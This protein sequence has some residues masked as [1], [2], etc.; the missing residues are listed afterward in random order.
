MTKVAL[1]V[2]CFFGSNIN[3]LVLQLASLLVCVDVKPETYKADQIYHELLNRGMSDDV[4]M[5]I[6]PD[7]AHLIHRKRQ[8]VSC[9]SGIDSALLNNLIY[10]YHFTT[11]INA[12]D[13]VLAER[14]TSIRACIHRLLQMGFRKC[15]STN[16]HVAMYCDGVS[17]QMYANLDDFRRR[18]DVQH[19]NQL[20]RDKV[21]NI[22]QFTRPYYFIYFRCPHV[23]QNV[24]KR[25]KEL[26]NEKN[27]MFAQL[28]TYDEYTS[29]TSIR[30]AFHQACEPIE[31]IGD[32]VLTR[33]RFELLNF[34]VKYHTYVWPSILNVWQYQY[35]YHTYFRDIDHTHETK[36]I[37]EKYYP[38]GFK[39]T[40]D[41]FLEVYTY[42]SELFDDAIAQYYDEHIKA[43]AHQSYSGP[44]HNVYNEF[45][46][47]YPNSSLQG[48]TYHT[49]VMINRNRFLADYDDWHKF[50]ADDDDFTCGLDYYNII[51]QTYLK[52]VQKQFN[53][54]KPI[55]EKLFKRLGV[56]V[57]NMNIQ[58]VRQVLPSV[59]SDMDN[60]WVRYLYVIAMK[61]C[62]YDTPFVLKDK[63]VYELRHKSYS[64][65][66][67]II[68]PH[69]PYNFT[70][71]QESAS[72]DVAFVSIH[73]TD[74][75]DRA[76]MMFNFNT[77]YYFNSTA[78][79][80]QKL[81]DKTLFTA[82][83]SNSLRMV[84]KLYNPNIIINWGRYYYK[85]DSLVPFTDAHGLTTFKYVCQRDRRH[86]CE[87]VDEKEVNE[88]NDKIAQE[89]IGQLH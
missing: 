68:P 25:A 58:T 15:V 41:I 2:N 12:Y 44:I 81:S 3:R 55:Y 32:I 43:C 61:M 8:L 36:Q 17:G 16:V 37:L 38:N 85:Y 51:Y 62:M 59:L 45:H 27:P 82:C 18:F 73:L 6:C 7:L 64:T 26:F 53:I 80:Y 1:C 84:L 70:N 87:D 31:H 63:G 76:Q 88:W 30:Y 49:N 89:P 24:N 71:V 67:K 75:T 28:L 78:T 60:V 50:F 19:F 33:S 5:Q 52:A 10:V 46:E 22:N 42:Q 11:V 47:L 77:Y 66:N 23:F 48:T 74:W 34:I 39:M 4:I 86:V 79:N 9:Q 54:D 56:K 13:K 65:T 83:R 69:L 72:E 57:E 35:I 14:H 29:D 40:Y 20:F 21:W